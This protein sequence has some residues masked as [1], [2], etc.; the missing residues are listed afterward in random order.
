MTKDKNLFAKL[1]TKKTSKEVTEPE[2]I[3]TDGVTE[4]SVDDVSELDIPEPE[5]SK[6]DLLGIARRK[7]D[8]VGAPYDENDSAD[9]VAYKT[10]EFIKAQFESSNTPASKDTGPAVEKSQMTLREELYRENMKLVRIRITNMDD[11]DSKL[12][13]DFYSIS[14]EYLGDVTKYVPY[15]DKTE[16]GYHVPYCIYKLLRNQKYVQFYTTTVNGLPTTRTRLARKFAIEVL[17]PLTQ[18]ELKDL[19]QRQLA[20]GNLED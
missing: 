6:V 16:N 3:E 4:E 5:A 1:D 19:A 7:A 15:G 13:G 20:S 9:L 11:K 18:N 8:L 14:N 10:E 17:P 2:V 12:D